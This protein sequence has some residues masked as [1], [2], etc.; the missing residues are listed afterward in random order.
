MSDQPWPDG[1]VRIEL[2]ARKLLDVHLQ[3]TNLRVHRALTRAHSSHTLATVARRDLHVHLDIGDHQLVLHLARQ[4][5]E[6][7][8]AVDT[9]ADVLVALPPHELDHA[10]DRVAFLRRLG[11]Q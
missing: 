7:R 1:H 11:R 2:D 4:R 8:L 10:L 5:D 6:R 3:A 9:R